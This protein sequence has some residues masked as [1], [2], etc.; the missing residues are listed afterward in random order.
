VDLRPQSVELLD[1]GEKV[2]PVRRGTAWRLALPAMCAAVPFRGWVFL[3]WGSEVEAPRLRASE[4]IA[5]VT[6]L[7]MWADVTTDPRRLLRFASL[8]AF[9]L[10]R[11]ASGRDL[12][13]VVDQLLAATG[14]DRVAS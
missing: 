8:P 1:A 9:E 12:E 6:A 14:A 7:R 3:A 4:C 11:P 10:R 5:R 13:T 2:L